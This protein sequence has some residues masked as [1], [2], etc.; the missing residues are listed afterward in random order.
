MLQWRCLSGLES[1]RCV[2][3]AKIRQGIPINFTSMRSS[4]NKS[5][6]RQ[7]LSLVAGSK[8]SCWLDLGPRWLD[9]NCSQSFPA[10]SGPG[11]ARPD[12]EDRFIIT[13]KT[14][15]ILFPLYFEKG[16]HFFA[17]RNERTLESL[18]FFFMAS[19]RLNRLPISRLLALKCRR[20]PP[21]F[22][23]TSSWWN[24]PRY[25]SRHFQF[26]P[27]TEPTT[28]YFGTI[29]VALSPL[30]LLHPA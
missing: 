22:Q 20:N 11:E 17:D 25:L 13:E 8:N 29:F 18:F 24:C 2:T 14:L 1:G 28:F 19:S 9:D 30:P 26:W 6:G 16:R 4:C 15:C 7:N 5:R 27:P 3:F 10:T 12:I 21:T 23:P